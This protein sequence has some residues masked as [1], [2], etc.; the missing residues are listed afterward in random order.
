MIAL[1]LEG[2]PLQ[3]TPPAAAGARDCQTAGV[4]VEADNPLGYRLR[5]DRCE[6]VYVRDVAASGSLLVASV[7]EQFEDFDTSSSDPLRVT[8]TA[9]AS[10]AVTLDVYA[11]RFHL[12]YRMH[13]PRPI[14]GDA[15]VWTTP[16]LRQLGIRRADLGVVGQARL[17]VGGTPRDVV[18][19]LRITQKK[20]A[21]GAPRIQVTLLSS[22]ELDE[23]FVTLAPLDAAGNPGPPLLDGQAQRRGFYPAEQGIPILL[24]AIVRPGL[25]M[26]DLGA[27]LAGGGSSVT[28]VLLYNHGGAGE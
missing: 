12:Y 10:S 25:L 2:G 6:G 15:Y 11:L 18:I 9:P 28:R 20:P 16:L 13:T 27:K 5:G 4:R 26:L 7:V 1:L 14:A 21:A 23:V 24:P 17:T 19:P 3:A 8:W 22:V